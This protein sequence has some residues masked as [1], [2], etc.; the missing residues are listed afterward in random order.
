[1]NDIISKYNNYFYKINN[2]NR[3]KLLI[4]KETN[5]QNPN[6]KEGLSLA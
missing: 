4:L 6:Q 2:L 1:M 5:L 3:R